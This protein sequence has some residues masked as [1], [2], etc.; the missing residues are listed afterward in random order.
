MNVGSTRPLLPTITMRPSPARL[1]NIL[2]PVKR[3]VELKYLL[4]VLLILDL[5]Q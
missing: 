2:V 5:A 1:L 4:D 3:F